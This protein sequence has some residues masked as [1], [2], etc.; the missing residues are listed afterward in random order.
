MTA[1]VEAGGRP[2]RLRALD[3][4]ERAGNRLPDP[5]VL[6]LGL[7]VFVVTAHFIALCNWSNLGV[8]TAIGG[9]ELL[10]AS[11]LGGLPLMLAMVVSAFLI[12]VAGQRYVPSFSVGSLGAAML[13]YSVAFFAG[14]TAI[15]LGW[16]SLNL[17]L[18]PGA[19]AWIR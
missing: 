18:R 12:L 3:G 17:P 6:F 15:L 13:P 10:K 16:I 11:G 4:V 14:G 8:L 2:Q 5:V 7:C 1:E 9:A 19:G